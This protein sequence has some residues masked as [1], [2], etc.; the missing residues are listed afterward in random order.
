[1]GADTLLVDERLAARVG[2]ERGLCVTGTLGVLA[3]AGARNLVDFPRAV[4]A[5]IGTSFRFSERTLQA[6]VQ[7]YQEL[8]REWEPER[9]RDRLSTIGEKGSAAIAVITK[10]QW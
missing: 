4:E 3:E 8:R 7:R 6:A 2:S 10:A 5:L 1:M 9:D